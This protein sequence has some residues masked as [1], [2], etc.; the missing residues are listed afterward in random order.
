MDKHTSELIE[1]LRDWLD[2]ESPVTG[3]TAKAMRV[4]KIGEE[5]GEVAEAPHGSVGRE[6]AQGGKPHLGR[7]PQKGALRRH[8]HIPDRAGIA[9]P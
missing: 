6:P 1:A 2:A 7:R 5:F 3:D 8:H 9:H 4:L